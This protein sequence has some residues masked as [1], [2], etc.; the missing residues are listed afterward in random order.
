MS[1][2]GIVCI[3]SE[4][5]NSPW[6]LFEAGALAKSLDTSK[7]IPLLFDLEFSDISGPLA[8]F[9]AKK[10]VRQGVWEVVQSIQMSSDKRIG[11][12]VVRKL[13][14]ALWPQLEQ[15]LGQVPGRPAEERAARPQQEV[16]EELVASVRSVD[17]RVRES[18]EML[19]SMPPSRK[20]RRSSRFHPMMLRELSHEAMDGPEDPLGLL[21]LAGFV[22]DDL[23]LIYDLS[24]DVYRVVTAKR[25][26]R[27][28]V[29]SA[30]QRLQRALEL[31]RRGPIPMEEFGIGGDP[32]MIEVV[33]HELDRLMDRLMSAHAS[34]SWKGNT[35]DDP[36]P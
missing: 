30:L 19:G 21:L 10:L 14:D 22:R 18:A 35:E 1:S 17:A 36:S 6:V 31:F 4:N 32:R 7:V 13:F 3:T 5:V 25:R 26:N 34:A 23:P 24:L 9:Q 12:D 2:F 29:E 27:Y 20:Y 15:Q 16:L 33:F 28:E 11:D 8:Q